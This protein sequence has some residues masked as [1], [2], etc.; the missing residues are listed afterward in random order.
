[1]NLKRNNFSKQQQIMWPLFPGSHH[2]INIFYG[3]CCMAITDYFYARHTQGRWLILHTLANLFITGFSLTDFATTLSDPAKSCSPIS[4]YS[5]NPVYGIAALHL[6]HL[7]AFPNLSISDWVHHLL[8]GVVI[9]TV[10]IVFVVGPI[11]NFIAFFI[12]GLPGALDYA[13]L[14]GVKQGYVEKTDEKMW[15]ARINVW[16]RSP[17]LMSCC[18]FLY[19]AS[20]YGIEESLCT[21]NKSIIS[22]IGALVF[23]NGQYYMQVVVGNTFRKV[24]RYSS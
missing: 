21:R 5:L 6:Y 16:V 24:Q 12:C 20:L 8:F 4:A 9:C 7:I 23:L 15:N 1:M 10:G 17:G 19:V 13:M 14:F 2:L 11:Q 22:V 18:C 3:L